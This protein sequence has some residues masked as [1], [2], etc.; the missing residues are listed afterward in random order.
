MQ[1]SKKEYL[2]K[3]LEMIQWDYI[4]DWLKTLVETQ[5]IDEKIINHFIWIFED[6]SKKI[7]DKNSKKII[8]DSINELRKI[9]NKEQISIQKDQEDLN[10]LE[11]IL[12]NL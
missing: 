9:S 5:K 2:I 3:L 12:N 6:F 4:I 10:N 8:D 11:N 7:K 1:F